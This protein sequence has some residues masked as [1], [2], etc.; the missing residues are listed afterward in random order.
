MTNLFVSVLGPLEVICGKEPVTAFESDKVRALLAFLVVEADRPHPREKLAEFLWPERRAG[1]ALSNLRHALTILR[2]AIENEQADPPYLLVTRKSIQFNFSTAVWVDIADFNQYVA[3]TGGSQDSLH[4]LEKA[5][6]LIRGPFL[7]GLSCG[8]SAAL[9]DWLLFHREQIKSEHLQILNKLAS[10]AELVGDYRLAIRFTRRRIELAPWD[11]QGYQQLM[12]ILALSDRGGEAVAQFEICRQR[13]AEELNVSPSPE[14]IALYNSIMSGAFNPPVSELH[15]QHVRGYRLGACIGVGHAGAVYRAYQ[16]VVGRDVAIKIILP[17]FTGKPSFIRRFEAEARTVAHLEHPHIVPL[18]DFWRD[19]EGAYLVMRWLRRGSLKDSLAEGPW[20]AEPGARLIDQISSALAT[21]HQQGVVHQDVKPANILLDEAGN[22]YL[23]DFGIAIMAEGSGAWEP[24]SS[25]PATS[26]LGY[27]SPE[28]V[29]GGAVSAAAD[30]YSLGVVIYELFTGQHPFPNLSPRALIEKHLSEPLPKVR[31]LKP[32]LPSDVDDVIQLAT[33]KDPGERWAD[34]PTLAKALRRALHLSAVPETA[35]T[36]DRVV[37]SNPYRGL[38][39]FQEADAPFFFGRETTIQQLVARMQETGAGHRFLAVVG[40]SG[41]GKSSVIRAGL[42]PAIRAGAV[43]G[44]ENWFVAELAPSINLTEDLAFSLLGIAADSPPELQ[45]ILRSDEQGLMK[46][47]ELVLPKKDSA[48]LL[49]I[50]QFEAIFDSAASQAERD[51]LLSQ[52]SA[53]VNSSA[54]RVH[55]VI[56]LRADYYDRPL[57]NPGFSRLMGRRTATVGPLTNEELIQTIEGPAKKS[58][59]ELE[60]GLLAKIVADVSEQSGALPMLQYALTE[61]FDRRQGRWLRDETYQSIGGLS[62]A[63]VQRAE[64]LYSN[65]DEDEKRTARQLFLRLVSLSGDTRD[66]LSAPTA[67]G[68][69][70]RSEL[71][72]LHDEK[73]LT[74]LTSA[75][76]PDGVV[77]HPINIGKVIESFGAARLLTFDREPATRE[78]T[79]E[80]AHEA[81]IWEWP[82]LR[83]WLDESREHLLKQRLL[84]QAVGEWV[85]AD[86][87]PS[88]L[89]RGTR[90]DQFEQWAET[91]D[92]ALNDMEQ[93][94]LDEALHQ[95]SARQAEEA[96][97]VRQEK[98]L[99]RR[100]RI[101]LRTLLAVMT[102]AAFIALTLMLY[103]FGQQREALE[104][105]SL[106]LIAH[107]KQALDDRD[108]ATALALALAANEIF[109]PPLEAQRTLLDAAYAPGAR[110]RYE[111]STLF[112]EL[113]GPITALAMSPNGRH[114]GMGFAGGTIVLWD[115]V[116]EMEIGRLA[117]HDGQVN[118]IA[119]SPDGH[120]AI[121]GGD[122][123]R[124][125]IWDLG[126]GRP[127]RELVGH[128]GPVQAVDISADGQQALSGGYGSASFRGPGQLLLWEFPSGQELLCFEGCKTGLVEAQFALNGTAVLASCG[129]AELITDLGSDLEGKELLVETFLWDI[130]SGETATP[131]TSFAHDAFSMAIAP[132]EQHALIGSYYDNIASVVDLRSGETLQVLEG[133]HDGVSAIQYT[134]DGSRVLTGSHDGSLILWDLASTEAIFHFNVHI[135]EVSD[136]VV[137]PDG[138]TALSAS[139]NGELIQWDL[140][141]A[142]DLAHYNG[143]GDMVYDTAY[144]PDGSQFLSV[145]GGSSPAMPTQDT[146]IRLWDAASGQQLR[147]KDLPLE[148]LFQID[149][150]PNGKQALVAGMAPMVIVLDAATLEQIGRLE[151]H[152]GW[153]SGVDISPDGRHAVTV[154]VDGSIILWDLLSQSLVRRIETGAEGGL[155]AVAMSP[156]GRTALAETDEGAVGLWD[157]ASGERLKKYVIDGFS[158]AGSSGIALLPDGQSAIA[159]GANGFIY[160]WDLQSGE[161]IHVLGQHNDIR[162]RIEIT[163]DG[164]MALSSGM[165][166]VLMLWDLENGELIR[167]FGTP[168]QMIFDVAISPDGRTALSGSS[169]KSIIRWQLDS[170]NAQELYDWIDVNR[171]VRELSCD[172]HKLYQIEPYCPAGTLPR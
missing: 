100:S 29:Q 143:H 71:E 50:D 87:D 70:P 14:T 158:G 74:S 101:F 44:S 67:R 84:A 2:R 116:A 4:I 136:L 134:A 35:L 147:A 8:D 160:Q 40:P 150:T 103:A 61:L 33:A 30:I 11:E 75:A 107:A 6:K 125:I 42:V 13:L 56:G 155:W 73:V 142:A 49:I 113:T 146:S 28:A 89:L 86:Q 45:R 99:E 124:V 102:L 161:L 58:G 53:A 46:A 153:V 51:L 24:R 159:Q 72:S 172:E 151:G 12:R 93:L 34:A 83:G 9:E 17:Q 62:G 60:S 138:R 26:S 121:S 41:C 110:Q 129:D 164:R 139:R 59:A 39:P 22:G 109:D 112:P 27:L 117:G 5:D 126:T 16:P 148:V 127:I 105:H 135:G 90:L 55:V 3:H 10:H 66:S 118:D 145:S 132:D 144:L 96:A 79:V 38:Q 130:V 123:G 122:D 94:F 69:V 91:T 80:V 167:R 15:R 128:T 25:Q 76:A 152:Q 137:T 7:E 111:V 48:L 19:P 98:Y 54:S 31:D 106:S 140:N 64:S 32:E 81:I 43:E 37:L 115:Y 104:A 157:L 162:T 82:R 156:N 47:A 163:P 119:F 88:F 21:A 65:L 169:D 141:D 170:P 63:L 1:A 154:S 20:P 165:D 95:R 18:Y 92:L 57:A 108:T 131:I 52:I 78:P 77:S 171:F 85:A 120:T 36:V 166:G 114:V 97:R 68:R 168:G 133:H 23:S 149:V